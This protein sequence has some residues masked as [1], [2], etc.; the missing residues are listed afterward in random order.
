M[1]VE[2]ALATYKP[3]CVKKIKEAN[4]II[5]ALLKSDMSAKQIVKKFK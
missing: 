1:V 2:N 4:Q 3:E 5:N